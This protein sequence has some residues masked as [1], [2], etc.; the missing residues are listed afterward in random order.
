MLIPS[1]EELNQELMG[2]YNRRTISEKINESL[3]QNE[4]YSIVMAD[5]NNFKSINETY[6][7]DEKHPITR[8]IMHL[9]AEPVS[10]GDDEKIRIAVGMGISNSDNATTVDQ[11]ISSRR[12]ERLDLA[13]RKNHYRADHTAA[14]TV[15]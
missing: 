10:V 14:C 15:A 7:Y 11:H 3:N 13:N 5:I 9:F 6:G 1:E 12:K 4:N 2:I 8:E